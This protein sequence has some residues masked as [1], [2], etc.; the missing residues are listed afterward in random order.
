MNGKIFFRKRFEH[1]KGLLAAELRRGNRDTLNEDLKTVNLGI[2]E[3]MK[4]CKLVSRHGRQVN[5]SSKS[6]KFP[7]IVHLNAQRSCLQGRRSM[8]S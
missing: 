4:T 5:P 8:P 2:A 1:E 7:L 6:F 3:D